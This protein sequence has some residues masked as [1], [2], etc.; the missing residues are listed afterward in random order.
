[1]KKILVLCLLFTTSAFTMDFQTARKKGLVGELPDGYIDAVK[2]GAGPE[3]KK[4]VTTINQKRKSKFQEIST[5]TGAKSL[6]AVGSSV[7]KTILG[8]LP[9]GAYYKNASGS[10]VRK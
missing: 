4:I 5:K 9:A 8:K 6:G 3:I 10:W 2:A 7:H 1:M